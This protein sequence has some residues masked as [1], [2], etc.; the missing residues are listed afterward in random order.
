MHG[1]EYIQHVGLTWSARNDC[2]YAHV[3]RLPLAV[4]RASADGYLITFA[5][6]TQRPLVAEL[7][8]AF[9]KAHALAVRVVSDAQIALEAWGPEEAK[10]A[11]RRR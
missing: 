3:G 2:Y 5:G 11:V 8:L 6:I 10:T 7:P 9:H 4:E 1:L